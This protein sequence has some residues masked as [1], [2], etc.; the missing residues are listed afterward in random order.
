MARRAPALIEL[1]V[2]DVWCA[3]R[4]GDG[5]ARG[6]W[7]ELRGRGRRSSAAMHAPMGLAEAAE[8]HA[9]L[10]GRRVERAS[11]PALYLTSLAAGGLEIASVE[12][13]AHDGE[14]GAAVSLRRSAERRGARRAP[15]VAV[16]APSDAAILLAH[17]VGAPIYATRETLQAF[18]ARPRRTAAGAALLADL[19]AHLPDEDFG[20]WKM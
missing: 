13:E 18:E 17:E 16:A 2:A 10:I 20:K 3:A 11:W 8:L 5:E 6:A 1:V 14:L 7:A 19:L 4:G 12:L 15:T 9:R